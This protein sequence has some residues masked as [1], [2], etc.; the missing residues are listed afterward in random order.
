MYLLIGYEIFD[1]DN[2]KFY[3]A[4][5]ETGDIDSSTLFIGSEESTDQVGLTLLQRLGT[6][7]H[8]MQIGNH[9]F[10]IS[11]GEVTQESL[12]VLIYIVGYDGF[13]A[14]SLSMYSITESADN[15][16]QYRLI[17]DIVL[18]LHD[19]AYLASCKEFARL[20]H[21]TAGSSVESVDPKFLV[22]Y[23]T[24]KDENFDLRKTLLDG[25]TNGYSYRGRASKSEVKQHHIGQL[26]F[27][28]LPKV[29]FVHGSTDNLCFGNLITE[30]LFRTFEFKLYV[31]YY[32]YCIHI[33][34]VGVVISSLLSLLESKTTRHIPY[35]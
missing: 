19:A 22:E 18:S 26:L 33:F 21:Y 5:Y 24:C 13:V 10:R 29:L 3:S 16:L 11:Q 2:M 32:N 17:E 14:L 4:H 12:V 23:L 28:E 6:E 7:W 34:M 9:I 35:L 31:F 15:L 8:R 30:Y 1:I 20:E 25:T 27:H